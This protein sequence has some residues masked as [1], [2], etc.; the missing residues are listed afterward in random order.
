MRR[1]PDCGA[2]RVRTTCTMLA[3]LGGDP[4]RTFRD[5]RIA[6]VHRKRQV[7]Y[8]E[9][10]QPHGVFVVEA[11]RI[12]ITKTDGKGHKL[13]LRVAGPGDLIGYDAL[14]AGGP[15]T[16]TAEVIEEATLSFLEEPVFRGLLEKHPALALRLLGDLSR[17]LLKTEDKARDIAMKSSRERLAAELIAL[18]NSPKAEQSGA[19]M[20]LP[21]TRQEL[22]DLAGLAQETVIRLLGEME[23]DGVI[24]M[25]GREFRI[26]NITALARIAGTRSGADG[27]TPPAA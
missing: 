17:H 8:H 15:Y 27:E 20:R 7:V 23:T 14:L 25:Q 19:A 16:A 22:A 21:Y 4:G 12:K 11:G 18:G 26:L 5:A 3:H 9:G 1:A 13:T 2:C 10:H 6:N 24:A